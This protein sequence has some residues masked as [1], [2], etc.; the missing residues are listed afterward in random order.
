M[1]GR[2]DERE[3]LAQLVRGAEQGRSFAVLVEGPAGIGKS[4]LIEAALAEAGDVTILRA[5]GYESERDI[6]YG[7]LSALLA[8][9][10]ELRDRLAEVQRS[11]LAG[12]LALEDAPAR[13]RF[14]VPAALLALLGA[15]AEERPL[16][17]VV[18][19]AHWLDD[20]SRE[21]LLFVAQ[22]LVAEGVGVLI[23]ARDSDGGPLEAPGLQRLRLEPLERDDALAVLHDGEPLAPE[24][25]DALLAAS[26]GNPLALHEL[27]R[28]LSADQ[29]AGL[30]P[31]SGP[32]ATGSHVQAS[33][34]RQLGALP[35]PT[36]TA[37][38]LLAA[39]A[40]CPPDAV[41]AAL[42]DDGT[43]ALEPALAAGLVLA[44]GDRL[45]FRHP[46]LAA[47]AYHGAASGERRAA[48]AALAATVTDLQH[49]AWQLSGAALGPDAVA[50][51]ALRAAGEQARARGA[52][53]EAGRA[54]GRA[55]EL[56]E[57][58]GER[59]ALELEAARDHTVAG[60]GELALELVGRAARE[61]EDPAVRIGAQHLRAHVL[62]RGGDPLRAIG[63]L[64]AL[65]A[66]AA[67]AG[68]PAGSALYLL[69]ASFAHMFRGEMAEL[70]EIAAQARRLA[71]GVSPSW[72][73]WPA[74]PRAR[75]CWRSAARPRATR[76]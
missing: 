60:H 76:C 62:M 2:D 64:K 35:A 54:F 41:A 4:V 7:G 36:R 75:R 43:A 74:S 71:E 11:A 70:S 68:D 3:R 8:P 34:E 46:L 9:V 15:A 37:L 55:A 53:A 61:A 13:D 21:A 50:V 39:G 30:A 6:P 24:V 42:G 5:A 23:A 57:E 48:H 59:A 28:A 1:H 19:D 10:L 32:P 45:G 52:H 63:V 27:P 66:Q 58:R 38:C 26:G 20:G 67:E 17:V 18:D 25:L 29:R 12:A 40:G 31:L 49:R 33:F 22:R 72:R 47:A 14:A 56:T 65:A 16:L 44:R 73:C 69:E 51:A